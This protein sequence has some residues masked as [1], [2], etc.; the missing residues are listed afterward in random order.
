MKIALSIGLATTALLWTTIAVATTCEDR[1]ANN[2]YDCDFVNVSNATISGC[3]KFTTPGAT[4]NLD[5]HVHL[6]DGAIYTGGCSCLPAGTVK[7][8]HFGVSKS[9]DCL[10][11]FDSMPTSQFAF[12]G[13]AGVRTI[14]KGHT[15]SQNGITTLY[16]CKLSTTVCQ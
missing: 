15:T 9:F 16:T 12:A 6:S 2:S 4:G 3:F 11:T 1:L 10:T 5:L 14:F 7:S 13:T 8:P